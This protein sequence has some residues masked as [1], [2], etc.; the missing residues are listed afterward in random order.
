MKHLMFMLAFAATTAHAATSNV[1]IGPESRAQLVS[2]H[3]TLTAGQTASLAL[4]ITTSPGWHVYWVNPGD[5]G[6]PPR[7]DWT[8][9]TGAEPQA[10][11]WPAPHRIVTGPV[12]SLGYSDRVLLPF[13]IAVNAKAQRVRLEA[14]VQW[15]VCKEECLPAM[16]TFTFELP[17]G[18]KRVDTKWAGPIRDAV[19]SLP[20]LVPASARVVAGQVELSV[21]GAPTGAATFAPRRVGFLKLSG[22][23][24]RRS[25][26]ALVLTL[27]P[28]NSAPRGAT[29]IAGVVR[30]GEWTRAVRTA[31][32]VLG[33]DTQG[34]PATAEGFWTP[35]S[36]AAAARVAGKPHFIA[37]GAEWCAPCK[38]NERGV[39]SDPEI[40]AAFDA[41]GVIALKADWTDGGAVVGAELKKYGSESVPKY[42]VIRADG[43]HEVLPQTLSK[44]AI[45]AA[46][47]RASQRQ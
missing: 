17:V 20:A 26:D 42:V 47:E 24:T 37:F 11:R 44:A 9:T 40:R 5:S 39:L 41:H 27:T 6:T 29:E 34:T 28:A 22:Q 10:L 1:V 25:G 15:L 13:E 32:V 3:D 18:A 43:R 14:R 36:P 2:A 31:P 12:I 46:L 4:H 35:W 16:G 21:P 23:Q 8:T 7:L 19:R 33:V 38:R 30:V 45:T